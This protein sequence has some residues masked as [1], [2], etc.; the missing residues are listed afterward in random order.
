MGQ[1]LRRVTGKMGSSRT[2][3]PSVKGVE[4]VAPVRRQELTPPV[5]GGSEAAEL[6]E[7][8]SRPGDDVVLEERDPDYDAMLRKMVGRITTKPGGKP[9]MGEAFIVEKYNRPMPKLRTSKAE[10][11][12]QKP[13]PPGTLTAVQ[14]QEIILLYQG[15]SSE[16]QGKMQ[17]DEIAKKFSIDAI[18]VQRIVQFISLL[19][20]DL[21]SKNKKT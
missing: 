11:D 4:P 17:V 3:P 2:P 15:K 9:E 5:A 19:P 12:G 8:I 21:N 13:I 18:Q 6:R 1:A 10:A 14:V 20:E 7:G 16:H